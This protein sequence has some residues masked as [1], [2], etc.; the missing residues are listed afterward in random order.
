MKPKRKAKIDRNQA[1]MRYTICAFPSEFM[2]T[3]QHETKAVLQPIR[4]ELDE[5][6]ACNG[7]T[8]T[9]PDPGMMPS[10]G[11]HQGIP[12]GEPAVMPVG[13]Q[14]KRRRVCI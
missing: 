4:S 14:R 5:T 6:T 3:I 8:E 1:E 13:E 9:G 11:K 2:Q 7:T 12:K 10:I